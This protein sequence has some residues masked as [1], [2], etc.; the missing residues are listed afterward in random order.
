MRVFMSWSGERSRA[1]AAALAELLPD[2]LQ[3]VQT[4]MSAHDIAAGSRWGSDLGRELEGSNFGVLCLTRE[5]LTAPW[6]L[7]E[8]GSLAKS[9]S[10]ARVVPYR[11]GLKS[12]DV[13][14][15]LAQFQ[16]VDADKDGTLKLLA[17]LNAAREEPLAEDRLKRLFDRWWP[18]MESGLSK[19]PASVASTEGRRDDRALLEEIL[20][21]VRKGPAFPDPERWA[22]DRVPKSAVWKTVHDVNESDYK[23][24]TTSTLRK[25]LDAIN[26]R[27]HATSIRGEEDALE[28]K[29]RAVE[30]E[31]AFRDDSRDAE[32]MA[33]NQPGPS[34][35]TIASADGASRRS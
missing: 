16:G 30:R 26:A 1:A 13:E 28:G 31:L 7:F 18:D 10:I 25:L 35:P 11:L 29:M 19:I 12:T 15:P 3:D 32:T 33:I 14:Y 20:Q 5:N 27:Y 23:N 8:A 21:L 4:W 24:M 9:V 22:D 6:L 17:S 2:V 34:G